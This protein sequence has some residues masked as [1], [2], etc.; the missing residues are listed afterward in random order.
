MF[1][2]K[3]QIRNFRVFDEI[4]V[5][6]KLRKGVN[7]IIGENNSGK[8]AFID[9]LRLAFS[10]TSYKK[11]LYFSLTDFHVD[12]AGKRADESQFDVYFD[13][14]PAD[15]YEIWT[16]EDTSKGELHIRFYTVP[17]KSGMSK[18]KYEAWG[19]SAKGNALTA[20]TIDAIRVAYFGALRDANNE[21]KPS[22]TGKLGS[23]FSTIAATDEAR[24][25]L[26]A[27]LREANEK[28]SADVSVKQVDKIINDNLSK[29]EQ[30]IL[31]QRIGIGLIEPRFESI[32]SS[33]H[34]WLKPRLL[35]L[36][37]ENAVYD[38]VKA[39][40]SDDEW[41]SNTQETEDGTYIKTESLEA[42]VLIPEIKQA[43]QLELNKAFEISQNGLGYNNLLFMAVVLGDIG[44]AASDT[45][46]NLL[47]VE[48]P[49]AHLHPQL[50][51]LV[52]RFLFDNTD[53]EK[54]QTIYTSH[55]PTLVS[56]IGIK[57]LVLLYENVHRISSLSFSDSNLDSVDLLYLE[58]FLDVTKSQLFF[59]KGIIFVEGICEALLLPE[60]AKLLNRNLD[61]YA[62]EVVNIDGV[63]FRP[64]ANLLT[65]AND[66]GRQTIKAAIITDDDRCTDKGDT[67]SYIS[68]EI[69]FDTANLSEVVS[70][71]SI[72]APS[73]R[74]TEINTHCSTSHIKLCITVKTLEYH[75][76][77]HSANIPFMLSAIIDNYSV[78]G[79]TLY[80]KVEA[81][82]TIEEKAAC[83]WLFVSRRSK[84]KA[85]ITQALV[86]R[87]G[88]KKV[89]MKDA[90]GNLLEM[91]ALADFEVPSNIKD[92]IYLV[93]R[94]ADN[95]ANN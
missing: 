24:E 55:S 90:N 26:I 77:L 22:R 82:A 36:V 20:E 28:I 38:S 75:L 73:T 51:E 76:S 47:L 32:A 57:N 50:Q 44:K 14:V 60:F 62:V 91:N 5:I 11:D 30:A 71:L 35:F 19:G 7:A 23:L 59:A 46:F 54:A 67:A 86:R 18:I 63:S 1:I 87:L 33:L 95:A 2:S 83:I 53:G 78:V 4:G 34:A 41:K 31:S 37:K 66:G 9:A 58:K 94:E 92:A 65:F 17:T 68:S 15:F 80:N 40:F 85:A 13:E 88:T 8:T 61:R 6:A 52:H 81:L 49:E 84:G 72:A 70:K 10:V 21:L 12:N 25:K 74:C 69:D 48:E 39:L 45:L 29:I 3:V 27:I 56:R 16:P 89:I 64:F 42:K 93:T 43:I 79:K